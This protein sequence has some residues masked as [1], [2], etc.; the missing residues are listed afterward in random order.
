[1]AVG[2]ALGAIHPMTSET[3]AW[4]DGL[5]GSVAAA[6]SGDTSAAA[7]DPAAAAAER[8]ILAAH[9][10]TWIDAVPALAAARRGFA[11]ATPGADPEPAI[12][13]TTSTAGIEVAA[14]LLARDEPLAREL[15]PRTALVTERDYRAWCMRHPD[16]GHLR[17]VNHW[18]WIKTRVPRQRDA[19]FAR[20]PLVPG[21]R[22]WLHRTGTAGA[23]GMDGR[24]THLWKF[25]GRHAV[26]LTP[27]VVE[28]PVT[29]RR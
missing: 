12:V 7:D 20:H 11:G 1:M 22:F 2:L 9:M 25:T 19:E 14:E 3:R 15:R 29:H 28:S 24:A 13:I 6:C 8:M 4:L 27:F 16:D 18:S 10:A 26:L 5:R 21:E 17:H 23:G